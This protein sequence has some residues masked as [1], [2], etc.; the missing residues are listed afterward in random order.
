MYLF[1]YYIGTDNLWLKVPIPYKA[2]SLSNEYP[3]PKAPDKKHSV[4]QRDF[5]SPLYLIEL[6]AG[7]RDNISP[8]FGQLFK[9][10]FFILLQQA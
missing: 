7:I 8:R 3:Y 4:R 2:Y 6:V 1:I 9:I 5:L 10:F